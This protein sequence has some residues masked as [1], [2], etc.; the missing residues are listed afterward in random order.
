LPCTNNLSV[1][2]FVD[3]FGIAFVKDNY[4]NSL[5]TQYKLLIN[6]YDD[7]LNEL[8][9]NCMHLEIMLKYSVRYR[10][11]DYFAFKNSH[12]FEKVIKFFLKV[13]KQLY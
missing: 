6:I 2:S 5:E 3:Q 13:F 11:I 10:E 9:L 4:N 12:Q 8:L 7:L 1:N